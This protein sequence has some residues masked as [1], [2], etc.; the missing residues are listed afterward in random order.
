MLDVDCDYFLAIII[1]KSSF[2]VHVRF[3]LQGFD[4]TKGDLVLKSG[5]HLDAAEIGLLATVGVMMV[6]VFPF[7]T[8]N[9]WLI[10]FFRL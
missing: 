10:C 8:L 5:E 3:H 6:K 4:I 2:E 1:W 7:L 9:S